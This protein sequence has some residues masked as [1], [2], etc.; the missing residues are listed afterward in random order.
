M[1]ALIDGNTIIDRRPEPLE[2]GDWRPMVIEGRQPYD[3]ETHAETCTITIEPD[4]VVMRYRVVERDLD[5]VRAELA[6]LVDA[7]AEQVRTRYLTPGV[8]QALT[9][10]EKRDQSLAVLQMGE[11]AANALANNGAAEFPTLSASV[12]LEAP[13]LYAAAQLVIGKYEQWAAISRM[14]ETKRLAGKKSISDASDV[15]SAR[16]AYEAIKWTV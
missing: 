13:S 11:E 8:G 12:P 9:Y 6:A 14:I 15:A 10:L 7:D 3:H 4:R 2:K 16:A 1:H 5:A